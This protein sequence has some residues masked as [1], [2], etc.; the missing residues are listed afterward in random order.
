MKDGENLR[1]LPPP[2]TDVK[3]TLESALG[4]AEG[5]ECVVVIGITKD[6][7]QWLRGSTSNAYQKS[8]LFTFHQAC[9]NDWFRLGDV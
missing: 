1:E 6:G 8:F 4:H 7:Q 2:T 5:F 9:M 3:E